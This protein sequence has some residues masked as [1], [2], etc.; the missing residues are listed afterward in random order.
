MK[1]Q[2]RKIKGN[3]KANWK[4][5]TKT[6]L[7]VNYA[8]QQDLLNDLVAMALD[9]YLTSSEK[10][11][12]GLSHN[13]DLIAQQHAE[14][15]RFED[16]T[17]FAVVIYH[18]QCGHAFC[19]LNGLDFYSGDFQKSDKW[20]DK[21]VLYFTDFMADIMKIEIENSNTNLLFQ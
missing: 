6:E 5:A 2:S 19:G 16:F 1:A 20:T 18:T 11:F 15:L 13:G 8:T 3:M 12:I 7:R 17:D 4:E 21:V 14:G 9:V 10:F